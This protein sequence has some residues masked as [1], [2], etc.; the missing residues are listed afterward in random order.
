MESFGNNVDFGDIEN[1]RKLSECSRDYGLT[2]NNIH[3]PEGD[4]DLDD[5]IEINDLSKS[6]TDDLDTENYIILSD[7]GVKCNK[8]LPSNSSYLPSARMECHSNNG[9][10]SDNPQTGCYCCL[11][12][13]A[14]SMCIGRHGIT[15][16]LCVIESAE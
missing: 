5:N 15:S 9:C 1:Q 14:A 13:W 7:L 11:C 6:P 3:V 12:Q 2:M 10:H 16:R 8:A 4:D